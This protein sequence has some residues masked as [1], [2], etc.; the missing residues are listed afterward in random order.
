MAGLKAGTPFAIKCPHCKTTLIVRMRGLIPLV[1]AIIGFV[2]LCVWSVQPF[3]AAFGA[4]WTGVYIL[5]LL[6]FW[7]FLEIATGVILFTHATFT[8]YRRRRRSRQPDR[9]V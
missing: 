5:L 2:S 3:F 8:P 9:I 7:L 4:F 1:L 6:A